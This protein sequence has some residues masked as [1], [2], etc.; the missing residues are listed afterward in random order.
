MRDEGVALHRL[1]DDFEE[2]HLESKKPRHEHMHTAPTAGYRWIMNSHP[3]SWRELQPGDA[4]VWDTANEPARM[5]STFVVIAADDHRV[6]IALTSPRGGIIVETKKM[7]VL[8]SR[9]S[10][11][12]PTFGWRR[13]DSGAEPAG[14]VAPRGSQNIRQRHTVD[15][16]SRAS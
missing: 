11:S 6:T 16:P 7:S 4:F 3:R 10:F 1:A 9:Y 2:S 15:P 5:A 8:D 14:R 12:D 13:L